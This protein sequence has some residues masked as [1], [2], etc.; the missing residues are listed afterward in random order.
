[1]SQPYI[2]PAVR[3]FNKHMSG[4]CK[5]FYR[6]ISNED[7]DE[8]REDDSLGLHLTLF[9]GVVQICITLYTF[10]SIVMAQ[11]CTH[12]KLFDFWYIHIWHILAKFH[13]C[14]WLRSKSMAILRWRVARRIE[15]FWSKSLKTEYAIKSRDLLRFDSNF[16]ITLILIVKKCSKS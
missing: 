6:V 1:M 14:R 10:S 7:V 12:S 13:A 5:N 3:T 2:G 8:T 16:D 9:R 4:H 15:F 11:I